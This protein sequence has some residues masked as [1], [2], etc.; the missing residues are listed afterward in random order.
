M[1]DILSSVSTLQASLTR[2][3]LTAQ[4]T[5]DLGVAE[6]EATTGLRADVFRDLGARAASSVTLRS[7]IER[8]ESYVT[9]N[10]LLAGRLDLTAQT[11]QGIREIAQDFLALAVA[12]GQSTG[13]TKTEV[14]AAARGAL[15]QVIAAGNTRYQGKSLFSGID[16]GAQALTEWQND[17][18]SGLTP[19]QVMTVLIGTTPANT[20]EANTAIDKIDRAFDGTL[21]AVNR[22][23]ESTFYG[24]APANQ[25]SGAPN[26]RLTARIDEGVELAHG[27]QANDPAFRDMLQ[28]LS[29]L[30]ALDP[31]EITDPDAYETYVGAAIDRLSSGISGMLDLETRLATQQEL[32]DRTI[33]AQE[34]LSDIY[35]SRVLDL[36]AVDPYE[37]ATRL[38]L[39]ETQLNSSYAITARLQ[40]LT[41]LNFL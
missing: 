33:T 18:P 7:Q 17:G 26:E 30:T 38:T 37:A 19:E 22:R 34:D 15:D 28:G 27:V 24:G 11:M 13:A 31:A 25:T 1:P 40:N 39:L 3:R 5:R 21:G 32:L 29:M 12:N 6:K 36:E 9:S 4:L 41:L 20:T 14:Q 35:Q 16:T 2:R 23:Y 8:T 10:T